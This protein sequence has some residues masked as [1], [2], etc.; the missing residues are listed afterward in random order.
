MTGKLKAR[1]MIEIFEECDELHDQLDGFKPLISLFEQ[2][3]A[4]AKIRLKNQ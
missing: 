2:Y 1:L 3:V 4:S